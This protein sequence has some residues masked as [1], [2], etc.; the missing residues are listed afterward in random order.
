MPKLYLGL[1][2]VFE[3]LDSSLQHMKN[4]KAESHTTDFRPISITPILCRI[5]EKL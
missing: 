2:W 3:N 5:L 1:S 4:I